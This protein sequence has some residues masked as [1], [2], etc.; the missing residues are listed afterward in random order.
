MRRLI[1]DLIGGAALF[2][3]LVMMVWT[4]GVLGAAP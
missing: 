3:L 2:A 4:A 1:E